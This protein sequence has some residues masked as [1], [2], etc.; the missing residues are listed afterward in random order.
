MSSF[1]GGKVCGD[2]VTMK[3]YVRDPVASV[4]REVGFPPLGDSLSSFSLLP[5]SLLSL[6]WTPSRSCTWRLLHLEG[7]RHLY[8][9]RQHCFLVP[10]I[11]GSFFANFHFAPEATGLVYDGAY[12][13]SFFLAIQNLCCWFTWVPVSWP[14]R[15][16]CTESTGDGFDPSSYS[17]IISH[18]NSIC[19]RFFKI[20]GAGHHIFGPLWA[21]EMWWVILGPSSAYSIVLDKKYSFK[22]WQTGNLNLFCVVIF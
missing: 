11:L 3:G 13:C 10:W 12:F 20:C 1:G 18:R 5:C 2:R 17:G 19:L 8:S 15:D 16:P 21:R 6:P 4:E 22:F 9:W 7:E 14:L